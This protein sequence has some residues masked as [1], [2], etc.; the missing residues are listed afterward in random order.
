[1]ADVAGGLEPSLVSAEFDVGVE[2]LEEADPTEEL[3]ATSELDAESAVVGWVPGCAESGDEE[4]HA[5]TQPNTDTPL[6]D[7]KQD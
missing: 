3:T 6:N 2:A 7:R 1:M 4:L 5:S